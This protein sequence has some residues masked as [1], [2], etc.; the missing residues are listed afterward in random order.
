M[1]ECEGFVEALIEEQKLLALF[2][3]ITSD[4]LFLETTEWGVFPDTT[5]STSV[6]N[7][8]IIIEKVAT[9]ILKANYS[10]VGKDSE[11]TFQ[12]KWSFEQRK[13]LYKWLRSSHTWPTEELMEEYEAER[14]KRARPCERKF[15]TPAGISHCTPSR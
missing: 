7:V 8:C 4:K 5:K 10:N 11:F 14:A 6:L 1:S 9:A 12:V 13:V 3:E 2:V 15:R